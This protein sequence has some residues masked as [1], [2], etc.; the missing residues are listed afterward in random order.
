FVFLTDNELTYRHPGGLDYGDY[1][2]FSAGA[3]L[4]FHDAEFTEQEYV[5]KKTWGHSVYRDALELALEAG[6]G[7]FGLF[8]H[9]QDR[10]DAALEAMV[11]DCQRIVGES[12]ADLDCF[13]VA[14]GMEIEL[15]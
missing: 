11:Q 6:V 13:A 2:A 10:T 3:D 5:T 14:G 9:N 1:V 15:E 8:H 4:L 12:G 7:R